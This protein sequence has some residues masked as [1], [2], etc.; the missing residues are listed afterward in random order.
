MS[1]LLGVRRR[2]APGIRGGGIVLAAAGEPDAPGLGRPREGPAGRRVSSEGRSAMQCRAC[3]GPASGLCRRCGGSYCA[4]HGGVWRR[5]PTC[6]DCFEGGRLDS[7]IVAALVA[8][9]G[10]FVLLYSLTRDLREHFS[11]GLLAVT[12]AAVFGLSAWSLS[13]AYRPNPWADRSGDE[14][15]REPEL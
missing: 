15:P 10:A 4:R 6:A 12:A 13:C 2:S 14:K 7:I 8:G 5:L 1:L 9:I 11:D 3:R